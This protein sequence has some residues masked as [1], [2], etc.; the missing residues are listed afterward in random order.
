MQSRLLVASR[1]NDLDEVDYLVRHGADVHSMD[2]QALSVASEYGSLDSSG[3]VQTSARGAQ[4]RKQIGNKV[5][6]AMKTHAA[7]GAEHHGE[8]RDRVCE[9][10]GEEEGG[11][12]VAPE[13]GGRGDGVRG[14]W[15]IQ[16]FYI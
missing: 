8:A 11:D 12:D 15:E 2:D 7:S 9:E 10:G 6:S 13:G 1:T 4:E 14:D 16:V 3:V 5:S